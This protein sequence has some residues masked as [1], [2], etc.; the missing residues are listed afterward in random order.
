MGDRCDLLGVPRRAGAQSRR[1][2]EHIWYDTHNLANW[3][4]LEKVFAPW[5][6]GVSERSQAHVWV[7]LRPARGRDQCLGTVVVGARP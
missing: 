4:T 5:T 6:V 1:S 3:V 2:R 7:S